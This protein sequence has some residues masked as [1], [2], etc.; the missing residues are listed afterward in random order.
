MKKQR[1]AYSS[2]A[3]ILC[4]L[5]NLHEMPTIIMEWRK[6][7]HLISCYLDLLSLH[8]FYDAR[9]SM[10]RIYSTIL[11]TSAPTGRLAMNCTFFYYHIILIHIFNNYLDPNLQSI[12]NEVTFALPPSAFLKAMTTDS[13]TSLDLLKNSESNG[14]DEKKTNKKSGSGSNDTDPN[15]S[16]LGELGIFINIIILIII[17]FLL[18]W[19]TL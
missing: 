19:L 12:S 1:K 14:S 4:K 18:I 5:A 13:N 2:N 6:L 9:F 10:N 8:S 3:E 17:R 11:Q 15:V 7:R 16:A